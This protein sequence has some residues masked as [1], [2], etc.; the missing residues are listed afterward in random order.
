MSK[1]TL[2]ARVKALHDALNE[3][4]HR[5]YVLDDPS[6]SDAEYDAL[7]H[8][9]V[10]LEEANPSLRTEDSPTQRIGSAPLDSFDSVV[11]ALPMLSLGNA[12]SAEDLADFDRQVT[13]RLDAADTITYV[14]EPKLDG[15]AVSLRYEHGKLVQGA[16]RGDGKSGEN[17]TANLRTI[18]SIPLILRG[19]SIPDVLEVRGE[20]FMTRAAFEANN[21]RLHEEGRKLFVNPRNAAAGGLRQLDSKKTAMRKLSIY[22][23]SLGEVIG[24]EVPDTQ[25]DLLTWLQSFGFPTNPETKRCAGH[26][27]CYAYYESLAKKRASLSYDI[28]GVVFKVDELRLQLELGHRARAPRWAIAQKFPAEEA[29]TQLLEVDWQIGRT[30]ALTPVARLE[31]VFVGGVT[32]TNATLHNID[33][34]ERKDVRVGD[35]VIVRRAGDVI[36]EIARVVLESRKRG[37][38]KVRLP[39]TCPVCASPILRADGDVVAR[40]SGGLVCGAQLREGIKHFASRRAMDIDGLGDKLVEQLADA[41]LLNSYAD[42]FSLS[43]EQVA[44][45]PRL[46]EKSAQNLINAIATAKNTTLAR[47]LFALGIREVGETTAA[48]LAAHFKT[49]DALMA[50]NDEQLQ[51]VNDVG[52]VAAASVH[53][54]FSESNNVDMVLSMINAGVSFPAPDAAE[55]AATEVEQTL[56]GN[57][58]VLT[59]TL[60]D[61]TRDEAKA[62]LQQ[63][64]AKVSG[65]VSKKTTALIAGEKAGSKLTK[66]ES[67][68]VPVLDDAG[69][70][71]LLGPLAPK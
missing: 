37:A 5:Y 41:G 56:T 58:Y 53:A 6:V 31:P 35:T 60:E 9:L 18:T 15:L 42:I 51:S 28:D 67:L 8:E 62:L 50:A 46:A 25:Y 66:A 30:G 64:G 2:K 57:T 32:V 59:G 11:H 34:I 14:A 40:C 7:F 21:K 23:Y 29:S 38:G 65:S 20:V 61:M 1:A 39:S 16:T 45:L 68:D 44:Q 22:C 49:L 10:A 26:A 4:N 70:R 52:P 48:S 12:F 19:E 54:F 55:S 24:G 3:H 13:E 63:L 36:P 27:A 33:E 43:V 71:E 47:F 69:L 17:V